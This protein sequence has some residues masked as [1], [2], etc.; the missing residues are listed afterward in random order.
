MSSI[1]GVIF[2]SSSY[3]LVSFATGVRAARNLTLL[4][5]HVCLNGISTAMATAYFSSL[6]VSQTS[7]HS[8]T[9][10]IRNSF[11]CLRRN[12][13]DEQIKHGCICT[14][15][16]CDTFSAVSNDSLAADDRRCSVL[17]S[18]P[19]EQTPDRVRLEHTPENRLTLFKQM[20]LNYSHLV[21]KSTS[22]CRPIGHRDSS[23]CICHS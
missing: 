17:S 12:A 21:G 11:S 5:W 7:R 13:Q 2:F 9:H 8:Q 15:T 4:C 3:L 18:G 10:D 19:A 16:K 14:V 6:R 22:T 23:R 1:R 20:L